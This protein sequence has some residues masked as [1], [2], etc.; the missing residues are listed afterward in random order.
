MIVTIPLPNCSLQIRVHEPKFDP[1]AFET[2][3]QKDFERSLNEQKFSRQYKD[4]LNNSF[5]DGKWDGLQQFEPEAYQWLTPRYRRGY[6]S[7]VAQR[8]DEKFAR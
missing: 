5:A 1:I 4:A 2:K 6:L 8:L 3:H 7:G